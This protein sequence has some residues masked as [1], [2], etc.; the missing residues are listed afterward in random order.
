MR[1]T[2]GLWGSIA[3]LLPIA[4]VVLLLGGGTAQA[5]LI[6]V[7]FGETDDGLLGPTTQYSG[8]AVLGGAGD[9]WNFVGGSLPESYLVYNGAGWGRTV[10]NQPLLD[11][12]GAATG[13]QLSLTTPNAF[14]SLE[15][16]DP[17]FEGSPYAALMSSFVF[18]DDDRTLPAGN[19]GP[20]TV[21]LT[22]L[23]ANA[24]YELVLY[25]AGD[26]VGRATSF[27]VNGQTE[28]V[29]PTGVAAFIEGDTFARFL[30]S[31]DALGTLS[32]TFAAGNG[33]EANLNGLQLTAVPEPASLGLF[34][35]SLVGL[36]WLGRRRRR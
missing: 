5:T 30:V 15:S 32:F 21:T 28:T 18:A 8:A 36:G 13:V 26:V 25:S 6:N 29:T 33:Q 35:T 17:I 3:R 12:T 23:A 11:A 24:L 1:I 2:E 22:G 10:T 7:Q 16:F 14:I 19:D 31:A 4:A 9:Q 34:A 20:G 27:T